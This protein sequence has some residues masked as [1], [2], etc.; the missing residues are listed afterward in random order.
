MGF[1]WTDEIV[2][3]AIRLRRQGCS[4]GQIAREIGTSRNA[5]IGKLLRLKVERPAKP[6][7]PVST[8][9]AP[10]V[11][12]AKSASAARSKPAP[13]SP[14]TG[15]EVAA[16][17]DQKPAG[18]GEGV[19]F[20]DRRAL[21]CAMPLPGWDDVPVSEKRVCGRPVQIA[22]AGANAVP[23]S[24]CAG[25]AKLVYAPA[26]VTAYQNRKMVAGVPA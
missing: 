13:P 12:K 23:T 10:P 15:R 20:L 9:A 14:V 18:V 3:V 1:Q 6:A 16:R 4:S 11:A 21:Q 22:Q 7:A 25:C 26:R 19:L 17:L 5:V 8:K 2:A 24:W